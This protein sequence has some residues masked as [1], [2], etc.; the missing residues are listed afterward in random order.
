MSGQ[1]DRA[2][3]LAARYAAALYDLADEQGALDTV[4]GDLKSLRKMIDDSD[5]FRRFIKSPVLTRAEQGAA[6]KA[7]SEKAGLNALTQ[8]FLGLVAANRR[9]FALPGIISAFLATLAARRGEVAAEVTSAAA[10]SETQ[11]GAIAAALKQTDGRK[12][13]LSSKVD[14]SILGGLIVRVGSRM[15]DSSIKSKLQRLKLAMKG[16]G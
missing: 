14:P 11:L 12:I 5:D 7:I 15:V 4:A 8:K 6:I 2:S 16:V 10:L 3:G 13:S 1:A 9:L